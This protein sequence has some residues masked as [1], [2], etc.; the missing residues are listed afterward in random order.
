MGEVY[1]ARDTRLNRDVAIKVLPESFADDSERLRRFQLE[2]QSAGAL[3]HPNILAIYD[4]GTYEHSPYLVSELLEGEP[5]RDRLQRGKMGTNKA[6]DY[7][8]QIAAGLAAA[9]AKGITHRDIKPENLFITKDGRVKILDFGL[10]K[11]TGEKAASDLTHTVTSTTPG[12]VM[13]TAAYM[14]PEQARGQA[15]DHRSDIFS[16]GCVL[17]EMLTAE[18]AFSGS[19]QADV[20]SAILTKEPEVAGKMPPGL[21]RIVQHCLEKSPDERLQSARDIVFALEAVTQQDSSPQP[22]ATAR[23]PHWLIYLLAA[24]WLSSAAFAYLYFRPAP[25]RS[26]HRLTFRR[27]KI[28][29]ARFTP[30]GNGVVYSAQWEDEPSEVFTARL[31]SA[32]S[33][34][35]GFTGSTLRAISSLGE[36]ALAQNTR[37]GLSPFAPIGML[38]R[39]PFSG[40]AARAVEDKIAFLDW[41]PDGK[42]MAVVR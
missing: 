5:L 28:H 12:M 8:R 15:V 31:D 18:R 29:T 30:D 7:A 26:F 1:K 3:N 11:V 38:A 41:S 36:M 13:G 34:A 23:K 35:L 14:S 40:G 6:V 2:A 16:F 22:A 33:R 39:A 32:G 9:H 27:G 21:A 20:M 19:T 17:Y 42:E 4:L 24:S 10:A 37:I 25:A